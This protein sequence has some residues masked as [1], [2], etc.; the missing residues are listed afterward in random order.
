MTAFTLMMSPLHLC[1]RS[2]AD[3]PLDNNS[4]NKS[5]TRPWDAN[6]SKYK[7]CKSLLEA[8]IQTKTVVAWTN[9]VASHSLECWGFCPE[10]Q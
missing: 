9:M 7:Y 5:K 1:C 6:T 2:S 4:R 10:S 3:K 8:V